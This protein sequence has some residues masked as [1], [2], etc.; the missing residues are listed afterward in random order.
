MECSEIA[1]VLMMEPIIF[2]FF[3]LQFIAIKEAA[4]IVLIYF[5]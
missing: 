2:Y 1:T 5:K 3:V 4:V